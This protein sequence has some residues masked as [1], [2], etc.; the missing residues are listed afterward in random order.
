MVASLTRAV[1]VAATAALALSA[2]GGNSDEI[3]VA[4]APESD[5]QAA[6]FLTQAS[7]GPTDASIAEVKR[8]GYSRWIDQQF[9]M[10]QTAHKAYIDTRITE[11]AAQTPAGK[12]A[13]TDFFQTWWKQAAAGNDQLR[14]RVAF[15]LS[16]IAVISFQDDKIYSNVRGAAAYYDMLGRSAFGNY[17]QFLEDVAL[18]P[19][20][21]LYLSHRGNQKEDAATGRVP[22]ENFAREIMQ[23]FSI[24]LYQLNLDGSVKTSGGKPVETY[25][26]DDIAGL[27]KVFTGFSWYAGP[28]LA[29]RTDTRFYGGNAATDRDVLPM[30]SYAKFHS[31]SAK[32]FLGLTIPA[33]ATADPDGDLKK[34][35]DQIF[36]HANVGPFVA[37]RLIKQLV[38]SNPTPEYVGRVAA[39]FNDN[40]SG[41]RGDMRA[42]VKAVLLD[43]EARDITKVGDP[44]FGKLR[45]P[46]IR[47]ANWMRAF[48]AT[49][50]TGRYRI[51][52]L[53]DPGSQLSQT[54]MVSPTVFNFWRPG[55]VPPNSAV[56]TA[57]LCAPEMQIVNEVSVAGYHNSIRSVIVSGI[58]SVPDGGSGADVQTA[59]TAELALADKPD[60]LVDRVDLL[61]M[62]GQ[63]TST[64]RTKVRD[65]VASVAIPATGTQAQIDAAKKNRVYLAVFLTMAAVEYLVQK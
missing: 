10:A 64:M 45:E 41:V 4:D 2:C 28:A 47:L 59:Y 31:I 20:M 61:L 57:G 63:M 5:A 9:A 44:Y 40:G 17:R 32:T 43:A 34:A 16:Q 38:T 8:L 1:G 60:A 3:A 36:N 30:Q 65:A 6:R 33:S 24:G 39:K 22:D 37:T 23:L 12:L 58:G 46:V 27:A 19:M 48:G 49:S 54:P 14:Q 42:V 53:N 56:A 15:A 50:Q 52:Y 18:H 7:F 29:D 25:T 35:L 13:P 11:L 21:G 26:H 51:S 55:Y 62:Y